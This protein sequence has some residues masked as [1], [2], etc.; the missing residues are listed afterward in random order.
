MPDPRGNRVG[1][2]LVAEAL[3]KKPKFPPGWLR[4]SR[5]RSAQ[6]CAPPSRAHQTTRDTY[7]VSTCAGISKHTR[8]ARVVLRVAAGCAIQLPALLAILLM[9]VRG[10]YSAHPVVFW[11][12]V[13]IAVLASC[14]WSVERSGKRAVISAKSE[15]TGMVI[16]LVGNLAVASSWIVSVVGIVMAFV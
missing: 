7:L 12:V 15:R 11:S 4:T 6:G 8:V 10:R 16:E 14:Y 1:R 3:S 9:L 5:P 2:D 13:A